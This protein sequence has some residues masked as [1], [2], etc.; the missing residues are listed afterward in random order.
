MRI[1][2]ESVFNIKWGTI[3]SVFFEI[4]LQRTGATLKMPNQQ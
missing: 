3:A 4:V 1:N 2:E